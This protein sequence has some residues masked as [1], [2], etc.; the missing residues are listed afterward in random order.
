VTR[1]IKK[2]GNPPDLLQAAGG[3]IGQVEDFRARHYGAVA[4]HVP[5][6]LKGEVKGTGGSE[7]S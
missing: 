6:A 3:L 2:L 7:F 4:R 5:E 1:I